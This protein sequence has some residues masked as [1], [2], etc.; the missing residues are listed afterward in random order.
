MKKLI[1][2]IVMMGATSGAYAVDFEA[3]A[4]SAVDLQATS[5][6][7]GI[8]IN[9]EKIGFPAGKAGEAGDRQAEL[10]NKI[11]KMKEKIQKYTG[12]PAR[13][14]IYHAELS[15]LYMELANVYSERPRL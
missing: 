13:A 6:L 1:M 9:V 10:L 7:E 8:A 14:G 15:L 4:V 5:A 3:L 12:D 2:A 11:E